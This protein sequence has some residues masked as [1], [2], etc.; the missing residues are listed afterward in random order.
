MTTYRRCDEPRCNAEAK[1]DKLPKGWRVSAKAL[2]D[3]DYEMQH[4]CPKCVYGGTRVRRQKAPAPPKP[5]PAEDEAQE[6]LW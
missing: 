5:K 6:S 4:R 1:G 3:G 2:K